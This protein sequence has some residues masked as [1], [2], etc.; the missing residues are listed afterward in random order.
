MRPITQDELTR[1]VEFWTSHPGVAREPVIEI[2]PGVT[3]ERTGEMIAI[4]RTVN[5]RSTWE[6]WVA[7]NKKWRAALISQFTW[8]ERD[9]L[10]AK[11]VLS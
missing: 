10:I 4:E 6:E 1:E 2:A 5:S 3:V 9:S 7:A 11:G 8:K